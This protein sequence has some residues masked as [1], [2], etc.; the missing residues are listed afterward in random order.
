MELKF[1]A[2]TADEIDCRVQSIYAGGVQLLLYKDARCDQNILDET[3]GPYNWQRHHSRD[4]ANCVVALWDEV[5]AEWIEKED[6]GVESQTQKEKGLASDSFKRACFNWGIGRELYTAPRMFVP[7]EKL[8]AYTYDPN[9]KKTCNDEFVVTEIVYGTSGNF[10]KIESVT[11]EIRQYGK[12]HNTIVFKNSAVAAPAL[13]PTAKPAAPAPTA[14]PAPAENP[15]STTSDA[16]S[17][18][19]FKDD[20]VILI[21]NCKGKKYGEVKETTSF[22]SFLNWVKTSST[23]YPTEEQNAQMKRLKSLALKAS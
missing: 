12:T 18:A 10:R 22:L 9:G 8:K 20:E 15:K 1:R 3:V 11:V 5:K 13:A 19:V 2:L 17:D 4:N 23:T 6:T 16:A 14:K 21:G 7:K